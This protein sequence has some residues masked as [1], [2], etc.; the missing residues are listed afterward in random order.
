MR[1]SERSE[2]NREGQGV[3]PGRLS[4]GFVSAP[5]FLVRRDEADAGGAETPEFIPSF[6]VTEAHTD[7]AMELD[8]AGDASSHRAPPKIMIRVCR[9]CADSEFLGTQ[10]GTCRENKESGYEEVGPH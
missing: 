6:F 2:W 7:S 10:P 1:K 4:P 5:G 9:D 3:E 8:A